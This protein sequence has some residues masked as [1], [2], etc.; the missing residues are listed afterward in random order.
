MTPKQYL[1]ELHNSAEFIKKL[2]RRPT[3]MLVLGSGLGPFADSLTD[4][5]VVPYKDI[6]NFPKPSAEGHKGN[7]VFGKVKDTE[8]VCFQGRLHGYEGHPSSRVAFGIR[9]LGLLGIKNLIVTNASGGINP[10]FN[11]GDI[12]AITNH[13]SFLVEDPS[14]NVW[15]QDL[16]DKFYDVTY[17]YDQEFISIADKCSHALGFKLQKGVY[18]MMPGPRYETAAEV[19]TLQLLGGD[20]VGM[21]TIPEVL[22]ARQ[23][24]IKVAGFSLI[25]NLAAGISK[26]LLSHEEVLAASE[27][28]KP[29]FLNFLNNFVTSIK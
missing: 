8:V 20:A 22:A 25:T 11:A 12:M 19:K 15:S 1:E 6:P 16:G 7:L 28:A 5:L 27:S 10:S 23:M 13:L 14:L 21:S 24:K 29:K 17:P 26:T 4:Q 9:T 18:F 3:I 2:N